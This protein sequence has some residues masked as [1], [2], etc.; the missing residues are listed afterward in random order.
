ML[1]ISSLVCVVV[2]L[3]IIVL[4]APNAKA[5]SSDIVNI[6]DRT[7]EV[8]DEILNL[9]SYVIQQNCATVT[10]EQLL[11]VRVL[12]L[13]KRGITSL[14]ENDFAG[15]SLLTELYLE[16]NSITELPEAVFAGLSN[17]DCLSLENNSLA[18]T[19]PADLFAD[20]PNLKELFL[21]GNALES[22]PSDLFSGLSHLKSL[23]L[24]DNDLTELPPGLFS[25]L[26]NL[27]FLDLQENSLTTLP[28][29]IFAGLSNLNRLHIFDNPITTLPAGLYADLSS[30]TLL[31][32]QEQS[33]TSLP[34]NFFEGLTG[35]IELRLN[36]NDFTTLPANIFADLSSLESLGLTSISFTYL[37][38]GTFA[39]LSSLK[40]LYLDNSSLSTSVLPSNIFAGLSGLQY[41][42]LSYNLFETLPSN[43]FAGLS[44]LQTIYIPYN[45]IAELPRN[46][47]VGLTSLK[48]LDLFFN[49]LTTLPANIFDDIQQP[50]FLIDLRYQRIQCLPQRILDL[51]REGR[52]E[53]LADREIHPCAEAPSELTLALNRDVITEGESTTVTASLSAPMSTDIEVEVSA[54]ATAPALDSDY[55]LSEDRVLTIPAGEITSTESVTIMTVDDQIDNPDKIVTVS[56]SVTTAS[57]VPNPADQTL[58]ITDNDEAPTRIT[59]TVNPTEV[60]EDAGSKEVTVTAT[61]DV[62]RIADTPVTISVEDVTAVAGTDYTTIVDD[63]LELTILAREASGTATFTFTPTQDNLDEPNETVQIT[64]TTSVD[65]LEVSDATLTLI[66]SDPTPEL[67]LRLSMEA[68][69]EDGGQ[70]TVTASLSGKSSSETTIRISAAATLPATDLDY[71][72]SDDPMLTIGPGILTSTGTVTITAVQNNIDE[73]DKIV[74]VSGQVTNTLAVTDPEDVTLR[75]IDDDNA[76]KVTLTVVPPEVNEGSENTEVTVEATIDVPRST[77]TELT[78][79]VESSTAISGADFI[80]VPSF[81]LMIPAKE[82]KGTKIFSLAPIADGLDEPDE[83]ILIGGTTLVEG[84]EIDGAMITLIDSDPTPKVTLILTPEEIE[85]NGGRAI[86]TA[87]LIP[88]SSAETVI[89]ISAAP[90]LPA[91]D[92]DY[93]LSLDPK[94]TVPPGA[95]V[96]TGEVT[97]TAVNNLVDASDKKVTVSG[98][99]ENVQGV[100]APDD[101]I[102]TILDDDEATGVTLNVEP[103]E[104]NEDDETTVITVTATLDTQRSEDTQVIVSVRE[105]SA[106]V[107][108]DYEDVPSFDMT[109]PAEEFT[110]TEMFDLSPIDDFIYEQPETITIIGESPALGPGETGTYLTILDNDELITLS[111]QDIEVSEEIGTVQVPVAVSPAPPRDL[112]IP[113]QTFELDAKERE[114][115]QVPQYFFQIP[116]GNTEAVLEIRIIDDPIMEPAERFEVRLSEIPG[117]ALGRSEAIVTIEDNDLYELRVEDDSELEHEL[118]L[119]FTVTLDP[120]HPTET[121][122]VEYETM[123]GTALATVDYESQSRTLEFPPGTSTREVIVR[124]IDDEEQESPETFFLQLFEPRHAVLI[125]TDAKA[126]GTI[127]DDDAPPIANLAP[128]VTVREDE[129]IARFEVILT[130]SLPGRQTEINFDFTDGTAEAS[131]D[132]RMITESP[133]IFSLGQTVEFIEVEI[134]DDEFYEGDETYQIQLTGINHGELGQSVGQGIIIDDEDPVTV[135]IQDVEVTELTGEAIFPVILS[136]QDSRER[137]FTFRTIDE[138]AIAGEDYEA[139]EGEITFPPGTVRQDIRVPILDDLETEPTETFRVRLSGDD[140]SDMDAQ[141]TILDDDGPLTVSIYDERGSEGDGSILLPVRLSRPSSQLVT[142]QFMSSDETAQAESDYVASRGIVIFERGSTEGKIRIQVLEDSEVESEETFRVTLSNARHAAIDRGTGIGTIVD[143]DGNPGISVQA[144]T[145]SSHAASFDVSLSTP[146]QVPVLVSYTT[147][148]GSAYA[149]EDYEPITGQI[150]FAPGEL[151]KNIEVKLLLSERIWEAKAFFLVLL[152]ALNA[153]IQQTR[154]EAVI[155][156]ESEES[157]Q[158]A[159]VSRVLRTWSS[160]VVEGLSRR[161]EGMAQCRVPDLS[162]LQYRTERRSLGQ[163]FGGCG[164]QYTH[165]GWSVWGQ[166]AFTRMNGRD[167]ALSLRSDVSAMLLGTDYVWR[168]GWMVGLL[169]AQSWDQGTYETP[170]QSGSVASRLTGFYPYVSYQAGTGM[171]AWMLLGLGRGESEFETLESELDAA[172]VALGLTG[173]LTGSTS[174]RL[175]YEVDAFWATADM[176]TGGDLGV[177]RIRAGVEG[178]LRLGSGMEPYMEAAL[179]QDGGDA[180]TGMG[181]ELGGG[182]R[183]SMNQLRAELGGRTLVLHTDAGLREWGLMGSVEYGNPGGLGP[184]MRVRPLWGNNYGGDLWREAPLHYMGHGSNGQRVELEMGYGAPIRRS[185][186][187]SI[188]GMTLDPSGRA[189][190]VGY[191]L[192]MRKGLQVSVATTARAIESNKTPISYGISARMD[193]KW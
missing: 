159:Y 47:L 125:E 83:T 190:R 71:I 3:L 5:Q 168:Q 138:T 184:S 67:T 130:H 102:L 77:D 182:L 117:T 68:L 183:W 36:G 41:I 96:T 158:N 189:Y 55:T 72:L 166:G 18:S 152:S 118:E 161:M 150:T 11:S 187:R 64:G 186:G 99:A 178:S 61:L 95:K 104:V 121:V 9:V 177:R 70:A 120:P 49:S 58:T 144:V 101:V 115:Y 142:V 135:S 30:L 35:L 133:L 180:E 109:I 34:A 119:R 132:Y 29:N 122:T 139:I 164:T 85:E 4:V 107:G 114:D 116:S 84:L 80:G 82:I 155:E 16:N 170:T 90:V 93:D 54:E 27:Q 52:I 53:I 20:L 141:G 153:D 88:A 14:K 8:R 2:G 19:L 75:I 124:I 143:N 136:G 192:Q 147:E 167:G 60:K 73:P 163:I 151:S 22:L 191:N 46:V 128:S 112:T 97:I 81:P 28:A 149:G 65:G 162:W 39:G 146:S 48:K 57:A 175:G 31:N 148:D 66:D 42:G 113:F 108:T 94:L 123:D 91:I 12:R 154:T 26:S 110:G 44:N 23:A 103:P 74:T 105:G 140:F 13:D 165:G 6:C 59:L 131:L 174:G 63:P 176:E 38:A 89:M 87:S 181:M 156:E 25:G 172:L 100:I 1:R 79:S 76:T 193:L 173:T 106:L 50:G 69:P 45:F 51:E 129:G 56:G 137:T 171:R 134:L 43:I 188:L 160:Q 15:L 157:I 7:P 78:I 24:Y 17:L 179:R 62:A 32:L 10:E 185:L 127:L 98:L 21:D 111:V 92:S 126:I 145:V 86:V 40:N 37:P 169:A 33:L